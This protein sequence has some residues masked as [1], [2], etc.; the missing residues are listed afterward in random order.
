MEKDCQC[1]KTECNAY[2]M[3]YSR[4]GSM[5]GDNTEE[6]KELKLNATW[7]SSRA[8]AIKEQLEIES[9]KIML[10]NADGMGQHQDTFKVPVRSNDV[11]EALPVYEID[12]KYV[13]YNFDNVRLWKYK[14]KNVK[15]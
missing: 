7:T 4:L 15:I 10:P 1:T 5:S 2:I 12:R 11:K 3:I 9:N 8:S 6:A 13:S 14:R